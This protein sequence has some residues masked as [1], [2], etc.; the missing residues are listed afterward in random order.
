MAP[1]IPKERA[2]LDWSVASRPIAGQTV[3]G[4]L[5]LV[6]AFDHRGVVAVIDGGGHGGGAAAAARVAA[7]ILERDAAETAISLIKRCHE[8]LLPTRGAVL[9]L[10]KL[11]AAENMMAWIG[12]GN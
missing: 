5:H 12:V 11:N 7:D 9:T 8:A 6:K 3:S 10:V 1:P 4:D 2:S